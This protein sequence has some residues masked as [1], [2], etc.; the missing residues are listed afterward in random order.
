MPAPMLTSLQIL[1]P[2]RIDREFRRW[3]KHTPGSSWPSWG[4][5]VT[6]LPR[7][8]IIH[9]DEATLRQRIEAVCARHE[10]FPI[11]I[12]EILHDADYTRPGYEGVF[13][14]MRP[15]NSG[16]ATTPA[17]RVDA[18]S[19][20]EAA[21]DVRSNPEDETL[22]MESVQ[23][24]QQVEQTELERVD[25]LT[26]ELSAS[27][28]SEIGSV[29]V[30]DAPVA[31]TEPLRGSAKEP[32]D[33]EP[34]RAEGATASV[35]RESAQA[36]A[37]PTELPAAGYSRLRR[38]RDDL[39]AALLDGTEAGSEI[40]E[41]LR[42]VRSREFRPHLTL[43]LSLSEQEAQK[44]VEAARLAELEAQFTV[45]RIWLLLFDGNATTAENT[46]RLE[47]SLGKERTLSMRS[48]SRAVD[49]RRDKPPAVPTE[50][51]QPG[52]PAHSEEN[53]GGNLL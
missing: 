40:A 23:V 12:D 33:A 50:S 11:C 48:L 38:L 16:T 8:A 13:L 5:H 49:L 43:A 14:R 44:I 46:R 39:L 9:L 34:T 32:L 3:A 36:E 24:E 29:A 6:L 2:D 45:R 53:A 1:L 28:L 52:T 41:A 21:Q 25:V 51:S 37:T 18:L 15:T 19:S 27:D 22:E 7:V 26:L 31:K 35:G 10:P 47:F 30:Y 20:V 17:R 42:T 4:G